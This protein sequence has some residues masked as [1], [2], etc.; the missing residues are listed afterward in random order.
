MPGMIFP[1]FRA[2]EHNTEPIPRSQALPCQNGGGM[3]ASPP[4]IIWRPDRGGSS[5]F[6]RRERDRHA[7]EDRV[8]CVTKGGRS[9]TEVAN[10]ANGAA[11]QGAVFSG[12]PGRPDRK[13]VLHADG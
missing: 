12:G 13:R 2:P 3:L 5:V 1:S 10:L 8:G 6:G 7:E 9:P 4:A 11:P